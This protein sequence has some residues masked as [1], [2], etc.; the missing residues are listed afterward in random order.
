TCGQE[1]GAATA[2]ATGGTSP[3]E[4]LWTTGDSTET[5]DSLT[6]GMYVVEVEN[7]EGCKAMK[8]I[9]IS[10]SD[11]PQITLEG[12]NNITCY[13]LTT[14]GSINISVNG[15]TQ[16][17]IYEWSTGANTQDL[18]GIPAG[19]YEVVV[20]DG[21]GCIASASFL[22]LRPEPIQA[23]VT[24]VEAS[25]SGQDGEAT[26]NVF[27]GTPPYDFN[28]STGGTDSIESNLT[29]GVYSLLV[30]DTNGCMMSQSFQVAVG[31]SNGPAIEVD[32]I[33]QPT[34]D[35]TEGKIFVSVTGG[36]QPYTYLWSN[37]DNDSICNLT[38]GGVY[39]LTVTD[40][41]GCKGVHSQGVEDLIPEI[42]EICMVT[43][44]S[45]TRKNLI[46]WEKP[47]TN[48]ISHYNIYKETTIS[49][50]YIKVDSVLY[51]SLSAYLDLNSNPRVRSY[52]YK[53]STVDVCGNESEKSPIHKTLHLTINQGLG[54]M[55]NLLWDYYE[56]FTY[57]TFYIHRHLNSTGWV[58]IDSLPANLTSYS[59]TPPNNGGLFYQVGVAK[60][61]GICLANKTDVSGGPYS[62]SLS[63]LDDTYSIDTYVKLVDRKEMGVQIFPNPYQHY[64]TLEVSLE[65]ESPLQ[66]E[67]FNILGKKVTDV[68][69]CKQPAGK[70]LFE[71]GGEEGLPVGTYLVVVKT[72]SQIISKHLVKISF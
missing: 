38:T 51:D 64:T 9:T 4:Y 66:I 54:Q 60:M 57:S 69:N 45:L 16:P 30:S 48:D 12:I 8:A 70:H 47:A 42:P 63:N 22:V 10:D 62:Q 29:A 23:N 39:N 37:S 53:I 19:P 72:D 13:G 61:E 58:I 59:D 49:N 18:T 2:I 34:C 50:Y 31:D 32:S 3:Y 41:S 36:T 55:I 21:H 68:C 33:V 40:A 15:G 43:V 27:G 5:T 44:D 1:N 65:K 52:R 35:G 56:G 7:S 24:I 17:Y 67:I 6:A 11:G 14:A 25:C 26:A 20:I 71:I 28:W 46:V